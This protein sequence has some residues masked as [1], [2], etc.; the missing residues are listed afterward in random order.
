MNHDI[1]YFWVATSNKFNSIYIQI[2]LILEI[3]EKYQSIKCQIIHPDS[4]NLEIIFK[5]INRK[6][7][8]IFWHYGGYDSYLRN[9]DIDNA[10]IQFIYHNITPARYFW[11]TEPHV[12]IRSIMGKIQLLLLNKNTKWIT[13]SSFN[14]KE[15]QSLGFKNIEICPNIVSV[16]ENINVATKKRKEKS[17]IYVGRIAQN[18]NCIGLLHQINLIAKNIDTHFRVIIVGMVKP[19]S[20]YGV[21]FKRKMR[22]LKKESNLT[23]IWEKNIDNN[24]LNN[25]YKESWLYISLSTHEGFGVPASESIVSGTPALYLESGGQESSLNGIGCITK[26]RKNEFYKYVIELLEDTNKRNDLLKKQ[27]EVVNRYI[28]PDVDKEILS[29]YANIIN[30]NNNIK[31]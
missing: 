11:F 3:L 8:F 18:K 14:Q 6:E 30:R 17:I 2:T 27:K 19:N 4:E 15:L 31:Y 13:M 1:V 25:Y 26:Q 9:I 21:F 22:R 7:N 10:K 20:L 12:S 16:K 24:R 29:T 23:L 28:S 5:R